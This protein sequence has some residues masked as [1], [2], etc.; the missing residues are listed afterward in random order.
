MI[1]S[2]LQRTALGYLADGA[3]TT[4]TDSPLGEDVVLRHPDRDDLA[5]GWEAWAELRWAGLR[6]DNG[7]TAA[8]MRSIGR[9][10]A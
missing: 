7:I 2:Y 3:W 5:I 9:A 6:D 8:G 1:L 4:K 10:A